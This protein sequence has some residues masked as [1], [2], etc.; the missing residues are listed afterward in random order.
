MKYLAALCITIILVLIAATGALAQSQERSEVLNNQSII[1]LTKARFKDSTIITIIRSSET[2]FDISTPKLVELKKR[3]VS[4]RVISEMIARTNMGIAAQRMGS[5]RDDEFFSKDDE[6]FFNGPIFKQVPSEKE[7]KRREDEA[8]I[9]GSQ[10]GS[11]SGSRSRGNA[12]PNGDRQETSEVLGSATVR[13][14]RPQGEASGTEPKLQRA[15]KLDNKGVLDMIQAGFS[16][17]TVI[18]KIES[19]QVEFD[20]S[21]KALIDLRQNRVSEKIIKAMTTAMEESK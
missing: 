14:I 8:M 5:L 3:G 12:G 9:F 21:P 11:K 13:I 18:R 7:A 2:Q 15:S 19:S 20:L 4:E 17:G 10:S 6:A 1:N 16:E